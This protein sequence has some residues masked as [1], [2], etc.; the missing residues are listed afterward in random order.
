MRLRNGFL[1]LSACVV[2]FSG[3][4]T[5]VFA[6]DEQAASARPA[7]V[8]VASRDES[9]LPLPDSPSAVLAKSQDA[10]QQDS[11][12]S[13]SAVQPAP[14][15]QPTAPSATQ[16]STGDSQPQTSSSQTSDPQTLPSASVPDQKPQRPVGTAAAEAPV[17]SGT[18]AAQPAGVAIAPGK[19]H[20][21]RSIIIK[22]G[23][24]VGVGVAVGT[25]V[26]LTAGTSSKPPGAH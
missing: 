7:L 8:R 5:A 21:A 9:A 26:A 16:P 2:G 10:G 12:A 14:A 6:Q 3:I 20:R 4:S 19:Q 15:V 13:T 24:I 22:V 1:A 25:T 23:A 18:T 17:V 11:H